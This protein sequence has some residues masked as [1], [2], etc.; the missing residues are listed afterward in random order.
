MSPSTTSPASLGRLSTDAVAVYHQLTEHLDLLTDDIGSAAGLSR[1]RAD[2]AVSSLVRTGLARV[3][4]LDTGQLRVELGSIAAVQAILGRG[5]AARLSPAAVRLL[6]A[7]VALGQMLDEDEPLGPRV[8]RVTDRDELE[9]RLDQIGTATRR[10]ILSLHTGEPLPAEYVESHMQSDLRLLERGVGVYVVYPMSFLQLDYLTRYA[11]SLEK[12]GAHVRFADALPHRLVVSDRIRAVVPIEMADAARGALFTTES[13]I[14]RS[15]HHLAA[16]I[17]RRSRPQ[18][19]IQQN[20]PGGP[21]SPLERR[22]LILM[23]SGVTDVVAAKQL[24][25]TDRTFRRYVSDL[26]ARLSANSRFQAGVKAVERGW[27]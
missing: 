18:S 27:I 14:C 11:A 16:S 6:Q 26:L 22:V 12:A 20:D 10:E 7:R 24:G 23:S 8:E 4:R 1:G 3:V 2:D 21:P 13:V 25:V 15:L 5:D 17:F 9:R 19:A